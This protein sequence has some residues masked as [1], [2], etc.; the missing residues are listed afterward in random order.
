MRLFEGERQRLGPPGNHNQVDVVRHE[1]IADDREPLN[2]AIG[3]EE[4]KVNEAVGIGFEN[5]LARV[6][7]LGDVVRRIGGKDACQTGHE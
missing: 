2:L 3:A 7:A 4:V 6:A 1:A 5:E